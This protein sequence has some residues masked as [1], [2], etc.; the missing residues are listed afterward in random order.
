MVSPFASETKSRAARLV[1]VGFHGHDP[2]SELVE[3]ID[4]G[5]RVVILFERNVG[6]REHVAGLVTA[7]KDLSK[8]PIL[9]CVDQ[10]GG[11]TSRLKEGFSPQPS[12]YFV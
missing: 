1:C 11:N 9:V 7:I 6:D 4:L 5:V 10:E 12:M 2:S 3:L 8:D